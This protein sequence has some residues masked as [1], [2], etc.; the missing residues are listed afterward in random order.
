[1]FGPPKPFVHDDGRSKSLHFT[2]GQLQSRMYIS[3]PDALVLDYTRTMMGFLLVNP[4]PRRMAM[5]GLGGGSLAKYCHRYLPLA[6]M[7]VAEID[8]HVVALRH[9]FLIPDDGPHFR[10]LV[11]DGAQFVRQAGAG[12]YD[13]LL[14]D[15]FDQHGQ[16]PQLCTQTF[17]E[18]CQRV[19]APGGLLVINFHQEPQEL[20]RCQQRITQ[21]FGHAPL[22]LPTLRVGNS[23]AFVR[24]G[25]PLSARAMCQRASDWRWEHD[26]HE[27][28][29][30]EFMRIAWTLGD[31]QLLD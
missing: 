26:G 13:V 21:I 10:V 17:Y 5:I 22:E 7:T 8:P 31:P 24:K 16:S 30:P 12:A 18:H 28:L 1:M 27:Q 15:G 19:L 9:E 20:A 23:V 14:V 25:V 6:D 29:E 4:Q 2:Y 11:A 3:Q